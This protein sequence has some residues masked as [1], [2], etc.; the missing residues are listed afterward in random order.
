MRER[1]LTP[2]NMNITALYEVLP[3]TLGHFAEAGTSRQVLCA[4]SRLCKSWLTPSTNSCPK[5]A[6][7]KQSA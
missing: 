1:L 6:S 7:D 5:K 2:K 4:F 3:F